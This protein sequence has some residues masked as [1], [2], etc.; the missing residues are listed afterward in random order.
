MQHRSTK[1]CEY[2]WL[3]PL[4]GQ[5]GVQASKT[6]LGIVKNSQLESAI[7]HHP[8]PIALFT[9]SLNLL[10][11][12]QAFTD[13]NCPKFF[14]TLFGRSSIHR[15]V[16]FRFTAK[17]QTPLPRGLAT[18]P[19]PTLSTSDPDREGS[20]GG[21]GRNDKVGAKFVTSAESE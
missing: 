13:H 11:F 4:L 15:A 6:L 17:E 18:E 21:R 3:H 12:I 2:L 16:R 5:L 20:P 19:P 8:I 9:H 1:K 10:H 7:C 14:F